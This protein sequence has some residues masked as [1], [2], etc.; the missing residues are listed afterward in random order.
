MSSKLPLSDAL[1]R[2]AVNEEKFEGIVNGA[3]GHEEE[4]GGRMT[5]S[6]RTL[7]AQLT[8]DAF[9]NECVQRA[10][11]CAKHWALQAN[12]IATED[13]VIATGSTEARTLPDRFADV[14]NVKDFGAKGDG[15]TD[16]T[17]SI[18]AAIDFASSRGGDIVYFPAGTYIQNDSLVIR[19]GVRLVGAGD[20]ITT[21][22]KASGMNK[23]AI[24]SENFDTLKDLDDQQTSPLFPRDMGIVGM[25]LQ[26]QYL[27]GDVTVPGN[28]YINTDGGGIKIIGSRCTLSCTVLNQAG[29]GVFLQAR[30]I[31][32]QSD[33]IQNSTVR[34]NI[35][36]CKHECL[37]FDG[38]ADIF[39]D[40]VYAGNA[41]S[42]NV[43]GAGST[44]VVSPTYGSVNGGLCDSVVFA[45]GAEVGFL[46]AWGTYHGVG[47]R[48]LSGRLNADFII[49]ES[50]QCGH[51]VAE[52]ESRGSITKILCHGGGGGGALRPDRQKYP[53]IRIK[54]TD[55]LSFHIGGIYMYCRSNVDNGQDKVV[56]DSSFTYVSDLR[57]SGIGCAGNGLVING[58]YC[59][60]DNIYINNLTGVSYDGKESAAI[61]RNAASQTF[62]TRLN[63]MVL[64]VPVAFRSNGL[65][66]TE[67][68]TIFCSLKDGSTIFE[69]D[70]P[71]FGFNQQWNINGTVDNVP[72]ST[73][74]K[75][76][77]AFNP[78]ILDEQVLE[79]QHN[80]VVAPNPSDIV[81]S[82]QDTG[83]S[84]NSGMIQYMY[85]KQAD[86][87][88]IVINLKMKEQ[89][90]ASNPYITVKAEI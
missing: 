64:S 12:K 50:N 6:L 26:G 88:K 13:A 27:S 49:S 16:D 56:I 86:S 62:M 82:I 79:V 7:F 81:L 2:L 15:V 54:T 85:V 34:L 11:A 1:K 9:A 25:T 14:V 80:L 10:C 66:R 55:G 20:W 31:F 4:L 21:I 29:V 37:I 18:Q 30:G 52:G 42:T 38:P 44:P 68:I 46:H 59:G 17:T 73:K 58:S 3:E 40:A 90:N 53:D 5:P 61:V 87:E 89:G 23:D 72:K 24:I 47:V 83:T 63:A 74:F 65:C 19:N 71:Q 76:R 36:T 32:N 51:F 41:G 84:L 8:G 69:G 70:S 77:V 39:I 67:D 60:F 22:K 78:S 33:K 28:S 75:S 43:P 45:T 48:C 35:N 57:I